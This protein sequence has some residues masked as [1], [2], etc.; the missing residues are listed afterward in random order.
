MK[1]NC[2]T[3]LRTTAVCREI[4]STAGLMSTAATTFFRSGYLLSVDMRFSLAM[5]ALIAED[6]IDLSWC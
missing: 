4:M 2:L 3:A 5:G 6:D 1:D